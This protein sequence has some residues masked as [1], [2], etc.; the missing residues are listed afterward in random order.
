MTSTE[1][2]PRDR[3]WAARM[4]QRDDWLAPAREAALE[5]EREIVD[6][7]HHLWNRGGARYEMDDLARDLEGHRVVQSVFIECRQWWRPEGE[8]PD[9][10]RPVGETAAVA[11]R[12]AAHEG[13]PALAAIVA[14]A[15]LRSPHLDEILDAHVEAGRGL[16]RGIRHSAAS[17]PSDALAI[18]GREGPGLYRDEAFLRG[19]VRLGERGFTF[20][21]WHYHHQ[22]EEFRAAA[23]AAPRTTIV[24]DHFG[25]PLG[26]GPHAGRREEIFAR[27][28][29]D[30]AA[31]AE[32][33]NVH[34]KLGGL[35]MIDNGWAFHER[36]RP[37]GS[38]ELAALHGPWYR[39]TLERFG[40][41]RCMFESNFPVDRAS[42][43]YGVF[44]NAFKRMTSDL[45]AA[46]RAMLFAGTAR[47]VY[48]LPEV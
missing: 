30:L 38:E 27:W 34:A 3:G 5:P 46:D 40:A 24:L 11:G 9:H 39:W 37:P 2:S 10:L 32:L 29:D 31:A 17:D 18:P 28:K 44:W 48:S 22:M 14:H 16:F 15:D 41:G 23:A 47:R 19:L 33:A 36:D 21:A 20:D 8:G 42:A 13:D 25:C 6:P 35:A 1:T 7:H 4:G 12:A 45:P 43:P 26:V